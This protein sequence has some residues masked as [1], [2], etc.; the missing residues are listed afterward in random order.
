MSPSGDKPGMTFADRLLP[1]PTE[2]ALSLPEHYVWGLD[3]IKTPDGCHHAFA[4]RWPHDAGPFTEAWQTDSE[5]V[6]A[7]A[8][9]PTGPFS[10]EET[11]VEPWAHNPEIVRINDKYALYYL[12]PNWEVHVR[13]APHP[14]GPWTHHEIGIAAPANPA[15]ALRDDGTIILIIK[16]TDET[17][18][19]RYDAYLT[20]DITGPY[21]LANEQLFEPSPA[22]PTEDMSIWNAGGFFHMVSNWGPKAGFSDTEGFHALSADGVSWQVPERADAFPMTVTYNDGTEH[23]FGT[24]G[25]LERVK[26][27]AQKGVATHMYRATAPVGKTDATGSTNT[28]STVTPLRRPMRIDVGTEGPD[29]ARIDLESGDSIRCSLS[30][31]TISVN[32]IDPATLRLG[33]V[34]AVNAG[35]GARPDEV[36]ATSSGLAL[37]VTS[38]DLGFAGTRIDYLLK[39]TGETVGGDLIFGYDRIHLA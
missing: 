14:T 24:G 23:D 36:A 26:V 16:Q 34:N 32:R 37:Q 38:S 35:R 18:G 4:A 13:T 6:R 3:V 29:Q 12:G 1:S 27:Y 11:V 22:G 2:P 25:S 33:A 10:L 17:L 19:R 39:V 9:D 5:I 28:W 20:E 8:A 30:H 21:E 7:T 15:V 31:P